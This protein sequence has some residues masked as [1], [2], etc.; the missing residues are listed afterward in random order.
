MYTSIYL[1]CWAIP[2]WKT[3][4]CSLSNMSLLSRVYTDLYN[5]MRFTELVD[6][7]PVAKGKAGANFKQ[8]K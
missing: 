2:N 4:S 6:E 8:S 1:I 7:S 3:Y 5:L